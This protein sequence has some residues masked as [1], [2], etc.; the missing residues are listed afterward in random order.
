MNRCERVFH[1]GSLCVTEGW[2]VGVV[3]MI[4]NGFAPCSW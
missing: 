2:T 1:L 3:R 4:G